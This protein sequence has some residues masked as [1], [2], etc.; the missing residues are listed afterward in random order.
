MKAITTTATLAT[1]GLL[2][3]SACV[4][5]DDSERPT[6]DETDTATESF[7]DFRGA[8]S[9]EILDVT[10]VAAVS[11]PNVEGRGVVQSAG[12]GVASVSGVSTS[13]DGTD[14]TITV[15]RDDGSAL[16]L[17]T[18]SDPSEVSDPFE[19]LIVG[20]SA[21]FLMVLKIGTEGMSAASAAVTANHHNAA[22]Y[23]TMGYWTHI[24]GDLTEL[25]V[26]GVEIGAFVDSPELSPASPASPPARGTA[27]YF[28]PASGAYSVVHG[29]DGAGPVDSLEIGE[30][31]SSIKLTAD[32]T[33][34][35]IE[36]CVG[37]REVVSL[38]GILHDMDT[39]ESRDVYTSDSGYRMQLEATSIR[40]DGTFGGE[41]RSL[42]N[43]VISITNA[44]GA[45]GGRFSNIPDS[46]GDPRLVAGTFGAEATSA[47]GSEGAFIGSF[48]GTKQ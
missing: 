45:W 39:G 47:G 35:T 41:K 9:D 13:F 37:C 25:S 44:E 7:G 19:S 23:L 27:S 33:A 17:N 28:G 1:I 30:F 38:I 36:G 4:H 15:S 43:R 12:D 14:L 32:F 46:E 6:T 8:N 29:A 10:G 31:S 16:N 5:D 18:G 24:A 48:F 22:E 26:T 20:H 11:S 3:L 42:D 21:R 2:A 40:A 34:G